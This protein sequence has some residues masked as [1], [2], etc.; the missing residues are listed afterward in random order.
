MN[1]S[2]ANRTQ[3][4][5]ETLVGYTSQDAWGVYTHLSGFFGLPAMLMELPDPHRKGPLRKSKVDV[6]VYTPMG[7]GSTALLVTVGGCDRVMPNARY[8]ELLMMVRPLPDQDARGGLARLLKRVLRSPFEGGVPLRDGLVLSLPKEDGPLARFSS[9]V[10]ARP[11]TFN[12]GVAQVR[13]KKG[14]SVDLLWA[15]PV[16]AEEEARVAAGG[17]GA[18]LNAMA[19]VHMDVA[20]LARAPV[21]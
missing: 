16:L 13:F 6:A 3:A 7:P 18:L 12:P 11:S 17:P 14:K 5:F 15:V 19:A 4:P 20:D 8:V 21:V 10:L 2:Q 9:L 1:A